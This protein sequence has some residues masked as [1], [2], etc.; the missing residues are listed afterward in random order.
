MIDWTTDDMLADTQATLPA[1]DTVE[2]AYSLVMACALQFIAEYDELPK[3]IHLNAAR[4][5]AYCREMNAPRLFATAMYFC[6]LHDG[7]PVVA[8]PVVVDER[9][10]DDTVLIMI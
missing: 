3:A 1:I 2:N 6:Y 8:V 5:A 7:D 4:H 10:N 9:L